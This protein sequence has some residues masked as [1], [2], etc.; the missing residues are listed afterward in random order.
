MTS[1]AETSAR[2]ESVI[3]KLE[4]LAFSKGFHLQLRND[5]KSFSV[6]YADRHKNWFKRIFGTKRRGAT[7]DKPKPIGTLVLYSP[8]WR[9]IAKYGVDLEKLKQLASDIALTFE[10]EC[11]VSPHDEND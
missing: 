9:I 6:R 5:G 10:V 7:N 8:T 11:K 2:S 3:P 4:S 1:K